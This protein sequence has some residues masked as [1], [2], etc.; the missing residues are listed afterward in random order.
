MSEYGN[1]SSGSTS[2]QYNYYTYIYLYTLY[3]HYLRVST[4]SMKYFQATF[5]QY[6][7]R[8]QT[9]GGCPT[10]PRKEKNIH[11]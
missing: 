8:R 6:T 4:I 2:K 11:T 9:E 1:N 7:L 3:K 5:F 10:N